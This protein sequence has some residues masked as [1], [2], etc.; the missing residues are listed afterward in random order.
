MPTALL[1]SGVHLPLTSM[2]LF[3]LFFTLHV[4][5]AVHIGN[6]YC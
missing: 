5:M 4:V 6:A 1:V 2:M 3:S